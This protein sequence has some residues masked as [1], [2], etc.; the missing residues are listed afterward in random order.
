M[1]DDLVR[2][3]AEAVAKLPYSDVGYYEIALAP[4]FAEARERARSEALEEAARAVCE[5][6]RE[7]LPLIQR[8]LHGRTF[9]RSGYC[10]AVPIRALRAAKPEGKPSA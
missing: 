8:G 1:T 7:G 10:H 4:F 3:A 9:H 5:Y 2:R 6:C